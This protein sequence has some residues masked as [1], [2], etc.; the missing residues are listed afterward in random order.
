[1]DDEEIGELCVTNFRVIFHSYA[2]Q[3]MQTNGRKV[4]LII[5]I[6]GHYHRWSLSSLVIIIIGHYLHGSLSSLVIIIIGIIIMGHY[7]T[8]SLPSLV[9]IIIG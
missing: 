9:I 5:I 4:I 2:K 7:H 1:M 8:W 3:G 6:I